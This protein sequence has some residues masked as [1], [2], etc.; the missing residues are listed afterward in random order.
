MS[1]TAANT[2]SLYHSATDRVATNILFDSKSS[3]GGNID[4]TVSSGILD[5][6]A[7]QFL[8]NGT[9]SRLDFSSEL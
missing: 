7:S 3:K 2:F 4:V 6:G 5:G 9:S 1:A 8:T